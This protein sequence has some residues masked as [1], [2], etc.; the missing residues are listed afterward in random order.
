[1]IVVSHVARN[2]CWGGM[3][4]RR[5]VVLQRWWLQPRGLTEPPVTTLQCA[6]V[7]SAPAGLD[8][9][10]AIFSSCFRGLVCVLISGCFN[11][12]HHRSSRGIYSIRGI[13]VILIKHLQAYDVTYRSCGQ[14]FGP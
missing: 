4:E 7:Q 11:L 1:M 5:N 8:I 9:I 2:N 12:W 14:I 13:I 3:Q 6:E 10:M